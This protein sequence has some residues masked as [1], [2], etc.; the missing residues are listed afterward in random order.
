M[1][2]TV[3]G[4]PHRFEQRLEGLR[5]HP[6]LGLPVRVYLRRREQVL[7]LAI[8]GWNTVFGY[9]VW[10]LLQFV[11]G[12]RLHYLVI[13]LIAWPIAVLNAYIGY[14]YL[15]FRSRGSI[16]RELPRF[17]LVYA[18]TLV[19]NVAVLPLALAVA[20][21][22]I[23]VVQAIFTVAVVACSYLGHK[24]FSFRALDSHAISQEK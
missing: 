5:D 12:N 17:S 13:V 21:F 1:Q 16:L 4:R 3:P 22:N 19:V 9:A 11:L 2:P 8:G 14:R 18:A 24:Y 20:P 15:V 10:A 23:Y 6:A 7:Y